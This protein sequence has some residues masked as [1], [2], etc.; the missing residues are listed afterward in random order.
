MSLKKRNKIYF[1]IAIGFVTFWFYNF[2]WVEFYPSELDMSKLPNVRAVLSRGIGAEMVD[3]NGKD[4][5]DRASIEQRNALKQALIN[6]NQDYLEKD[7]R[8]YIRSFLA[9]D[10]S[11]IANY[12]RFLFGDGGGEQRYGFFPKYTGYNNFS[13]FLDKLIMW[14][15]DEPEKKTR[16]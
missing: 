12:T 6:H 16:I 8:L 4:S 15:W 3:K 2:R 13:Y 10:E 7:G 9:R 1:L 11:E 5:W 14:N